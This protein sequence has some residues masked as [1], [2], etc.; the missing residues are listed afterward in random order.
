MEKNVSLATRIAYCL[1][2]LGA[3][4]PIGLATSGWV[5]MATGG[6]FAKTIPFAGPILILVIGLYRIFV[7]IRTPSVLSSPHVS[8]F[9]VFLR[10]AGIVLLYIGAV[11][12]VLSWISG[13]LML[14]LMRSRSESGVAFFM[15][16]VFFFYLG[17]VG[18]FGLLL[19]ELAR[20][21]SFERQVPTSLPQPKAELNPPTLQNKDT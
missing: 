15:A 21:R 18:T 5:M 7:V 11:G 9:L 3:I 6:S 2:V 20:L 19:F 13:P 14:A 17:S 1:T 4:L 16:G 10:N 12:A 8:G